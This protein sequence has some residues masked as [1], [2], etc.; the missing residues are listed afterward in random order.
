MPSFKRNIFQ[1][2][3]NSVPYQDLDTFVGRLLLNIIK[4]VP[5]PI[6][7]SNASVE[8]SENGIDFVNS[9]AQNSSNPLKLL[10]TYEADWA[11]NYTIDT[12]AQPN[13]TTNVYTVVY[14]INF[15]YSTSGSNTRNADR[16]VLLKAMDTVKLLI[17]NNDVSTYING[18][19]QDDYYYETTINGVRYLSN[20]TTNKKVPTPLDNQVFNDL[21]QT[22]F[23]RS[24]ISIAITIKK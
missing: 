16:E 15:K 22:N 10:I 20:L 23:L 19:S 21:N 17:C 12:T 2:S 9:I 11:S 4:T 7:L 8:Q 1:T 14:N 6:E 18:V 3:L 24:A 5:V 13:N